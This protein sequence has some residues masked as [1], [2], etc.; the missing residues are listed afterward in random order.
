[1]SPG[2]EQK[3]FNLLHK[4]PPSGFIYSTAL[5]PSVIGSTHDQAERTLYKPLMYLIHQINNSLIVFLNES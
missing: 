3:V 1:M 4:G 2:C 5:E